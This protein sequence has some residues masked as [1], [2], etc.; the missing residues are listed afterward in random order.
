M[1][2]ILVTH[3]EWALTFYSIEEQAALAAG[4]GVWF[5]R[6]FVSTTHRCG[7]TPMET[8][9]GAIDA[10]GPATT[11][12]STDLGQPDTPPPA[13]GLEIYA[14]RLRSLGLSREDLRTMMVDVPAG[15]L[16]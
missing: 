8:I 1:R 15:L 9:A 2:R 4:G 12:L 6:C 3:P 16:R 13:L 7:F 5:E 10:L 11:V 14:G